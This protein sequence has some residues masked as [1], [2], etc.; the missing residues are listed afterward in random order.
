MVLDK[1]EIKEYAPPNE[2]LENKE[3]IFY[4]M[5]RDVGLV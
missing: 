5:A 3:S 4:G 1:G 2:L